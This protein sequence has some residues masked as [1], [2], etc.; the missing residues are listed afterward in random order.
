MNTNA[1]IG[2]PFKAHGETNEGLDCWGLVRLF[3]RENYSILLS[4]FKSAYKNVSER[5]GINAIIDNQVKKWVKVEREELIPGDLVLLAI[6]GNKCHIGI[7]IDNNKMLHA[8]EKA[9]VVVESFNVLRWRERVSGF[10][11]HNERA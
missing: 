11:R 7:N 3:Y 6:G 2:T 1:Y 8:D 9:G 5:R 10:Y 4:D